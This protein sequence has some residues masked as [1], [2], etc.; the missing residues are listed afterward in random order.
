MTQRDASDSRKYL[1]GYTAYERLTDAQIEAMAET[2]WDFAWNSDPNDPY[3]M[4]K[5]WADAGG[6]ARRNYR[7][8]ARA[9]FLA[10]QTGTPQHGWYGDVANHEREAAS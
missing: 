1:S 4:K 8:W 3:F 2:L 6:P 9:V 7:T 5:M 10:A